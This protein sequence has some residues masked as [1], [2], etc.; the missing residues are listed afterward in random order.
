MTRVYVGPWWTNL[1]NPT[2]KHPR[3]TT[4]LRNLKSLAGYGWNLKNTPLEKEKHRPKPPILGFKILVDWGCSWL[5]QNHR[6]VLCQNQRSK[7]TV[8][9]GVRFTRLQ[10]GLLNLTGKMQRPPKFHGRIC[11]IFRETHQEFPQ[12]L[13]NIM[14]IQEEN[15]CG[16]FDLL[17]LEILR[18]QWIG[19][20]N[21]TQ[22]GWCWW[23]FCTQQKGVS[24]PFEVP[25]IS[26]FS[27]ILGSGTSP[28][29]P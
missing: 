15:T 14:R 2:K 7:E 28:E 22:V 25:R 27:D 3:T 29:H 12:N 17:S 19:E 21:S 16:I 5:P 11:L 18:Y 13:W 1:E 20:G 23:V 9:I 6:W 24:L 8:L 10:L 26:W 4:N